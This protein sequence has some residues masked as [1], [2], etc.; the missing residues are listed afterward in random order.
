[1]LRRI[2][3]VAFESI[4]GRI[5]SW[6]I[7]RS[8][9]GNVRTYLGQSHLMG[10]LLATDLEL[11]ALRLPPLRKRHTDCGISAA[12]GGETGRPLRSRGLMWIPVLCLGLA[13]VMF[14]MAFNWIYIAIGFGFLRFL[15]QGSMMMTCANLVSHG[16]IKNGGWRWV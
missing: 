1:M 2:K 6:V 15:G 8:D 10:L 11:L 12:S 3:T 16:S 5:F 13:A 14:S 4:Q 9:A 7:R